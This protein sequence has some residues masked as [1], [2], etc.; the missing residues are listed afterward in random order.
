MNMLIEFLAMELRIPLRGIT[1]EK[2]F[3]QNRE[4]FGFSITV[5]AMMLNG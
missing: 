3:A 5:Q 4:D 1:E 2:S